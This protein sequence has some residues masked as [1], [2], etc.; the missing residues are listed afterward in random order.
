MN[1]FALLV[2][3][4]LIT[5]CSSPLPG[6]TPTFVHLGPTF[7][8][9]Q[10]PSSAPTTAPTPAPAPT[11][12]VDAPL[13]AGTVERL[14]SVLS[15]YADEGELASMSAAVI[16]PGV[17]HWEAA[18]GRA[19]RDT[20]ATSDTVYAIGGVTRT[21]VAALM[22]LLA[23]EGYFDLEDS[24][25][26]Y[27]GP[28][29]A[30]KSNGAT[31]RDLLGQRSGIDSYLAHVDFDRDWTLEE[32]LER[33]G[34]PIYRVPPGPP[35]GSSTNFLLLGFIAES[36][37]GGPLGLLLQEYLLDRFDLTRTYY[38]FTETADEP[39]AHGYELVDGKL[40]DTYDLSGYLPSF[41]EVSVLR[42][43]GAMAS[44]APELARWLSLLCGG[45]VLSAAGQAQMF[46]FFVE[47]TDGTGLGIYRHH[48]ATVGNVIGATGSTTGSAA[49]AY[50]DEDTGT[51]VAVL[52]TGEFVD[53]LPIVSLYFAA[54]S[55]A[56]T[57]I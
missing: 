35:D 13:T 19:N 51:V 49:S 52:S 16:V 39:L 50:C 10:A 22:L 4:L 27:L 41:N 23:D 53:P 48:D 14:E 40:V 47:G 54:A 36:V 15:R 7:I 1:A 31:I 38:T 57:D 24:A 42:S 34:D 8:A 43:D 9:T 32:L 18:A 28:L 17:G 29:G 26:D 21:F 37:T 11:A 20:P 30:S 44:S 46:D 12:I 6:P 55:H 5:A 56:L 25:A 3:A 33:V 45:E 2:V